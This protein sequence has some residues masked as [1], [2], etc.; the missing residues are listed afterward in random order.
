MSYPFSHIIQE[1]N[2]KSQSNLLRVRIQGN[3]ESVGGDRE[4]REGRD[5]GDRVEKHNTTVFVC[6]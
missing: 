4:N 3:R 5:G 2:G 1:L 6:E